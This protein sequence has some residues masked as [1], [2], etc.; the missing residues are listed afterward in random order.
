MNTTA[1]PAKAYLNPENFVTPRDKLNRDYAIAQA[2]KGQQISNSAKLVSISCTGCWA[3]NM[4]DD[5]HVTSY[6]RIGYHV[7]TAELLSGFLAGHAPIVVWRETADGIT[8]TEVK[9]ATN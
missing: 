3:A 6:E 1:L 4:E 9:H 7:N 5:S 8:A 2:Q